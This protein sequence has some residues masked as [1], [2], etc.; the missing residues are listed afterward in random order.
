[1]QRLNCSAIQEIYSDG[2]MLIL[3]THD[4][5][6]AYDVESIWQ[7]S[8]QEPSKPLWSVSYIS[9]ELLV[10]RPYLL[11]ATHHGLKE[12]H[13][14]TGREQN[15]IFLPDQHISLS[16]EIVG[17]PLSID[18]VKDGQL[19]RTCLIPFE[20]KLFVTNHGK[21]NQFRM[22]FKFTGK[23]FKHL[24]SEKIPEKLIENLKPLENVLI[25]GEKK[26]VETLQSVVGMEN[27]EKFANTLLKYA[28]NQNHRI[29]TM[30]NEHSILGVQGI[31][32]SSL[33]VYFQNGYYKTVSLDNIGDIPEDYYLD[34]REKI[35]GFKSDDEQVKSMWLFD[36]ALY[37][38]SVDFQG[39]AKLRMWNRNEN[40]LLLEE[41]LEEAIAHLPQINKQIPNQFYLDSNNIFHCLQGGKHW[42][43]YL[44]NADKL[45]LQMDPSITQWR[46]H[47]FLNLGNQ[48]LAL[49]PFT[50]EKTRMTGASHIL[51]RLI[52][53]GSDKLVGD[54]LAQVRIEN[55]S[56]AFP[57]LVAAGDYL[58]AAID[59]H[60]ILFKPQE[61]L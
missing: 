53:E 28:V 27:T 54:G 41:A 47:N 11:L 61:I 19:E 10:S 23:V 43:L 13:I 37:A 1:M 51:I 39:K 17:S 58:V 46:H 38:V 57:L 42:Q 18:R 36:G 49:I 25:N 8:S 12:I 24:K 9:P 21:Y 56:S 14:P 31:D 32:E 5:V 3:K 7:Y 59:H 60:I 15:F 55:A 52:T 6:Q 44:M 50:V 16:N 4:A 26:F 22:A 30:E 20:N 48:Y 45:Q 40:A 35:P 34:T 29:L 33:L 2:Q